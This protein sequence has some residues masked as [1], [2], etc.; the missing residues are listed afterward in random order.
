MKSQ[1]RGVLCRHSTQTLTFTGITFST[2]YKQIFTHQFPSTHIKQQFSLKASTLHT[3]KSVPSQYQY[4]DTL[5]HKKSSRG[6]LS[7]PHEENI[8]K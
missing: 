6:E 7:P 8:K 5:D 2:T 1:N 3:L 4:N